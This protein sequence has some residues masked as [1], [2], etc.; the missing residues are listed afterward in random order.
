MTYLGSKREQL[1]PPVHS[2]HLPLIPL[3]LFLSL[4][5][6]LKDLFMDLQTLFESQTNVS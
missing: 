3:A 2:T 1:G 5:S 4:G 6:W